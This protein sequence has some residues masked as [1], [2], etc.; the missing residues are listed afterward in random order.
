MN[1]NNTDNIK[2]L[3]NEE[4]ANVSGGVLTESNI[5]SLDNMIKLYKDGSTLAKALTDESAIWDEY[6]SCGVP[7]SWNQT[8]R[9]E[10][11]NYVK[12]HW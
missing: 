12:C 6:E 8:N 2:K 9:A 3:T 11:L 1:N 10:C 7:D 4:L 5:K